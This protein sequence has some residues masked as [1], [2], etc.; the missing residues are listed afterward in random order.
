MSAARARL[1]DALRARRESLARREEEATAKAAAG[2]AAASDDRGKGAPPRG[3]I[4]S[5]IVVGGG[6]GDDET[7]AE[8]ER[9]IDASVLAWEEAAGE[10]EAVPSLPTLARASL[11]EARLRVR[12]ASVALGEVISAEEEQQL[13]QA[14]S[15]RGRGDISVVGGAIGASRN[16]R[17]RQRKPVSPPPPHDR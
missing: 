10:A 14:R 6:A 8:E 3:D 13:Q 7:E 17:Q 2:A 4:E 1:S 12:E 5:G 9:R 15:R 11:G 16:S